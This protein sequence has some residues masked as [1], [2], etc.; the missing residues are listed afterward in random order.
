VDVEDRKIGL[1]LKR[2]QWT[3]DAPGGADAFKPRHESLGG[4]M[5]DHGAMGT[6]KITFGPGGSKPDDKS[7]DKS[8]DES[9]E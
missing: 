1:S 9:N 3:A 7:E 5:D 8:D 6:D 4:G 2:A